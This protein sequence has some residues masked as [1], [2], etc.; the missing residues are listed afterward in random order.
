[1]KG[2][3]RATGFP[4]AWRAASRAARVHATTG[5]AS[6]G[7]FSYVVARRLG[8]ASIWP[9]FKRNERLRIELE[10]LKVIIW[11]VIRFK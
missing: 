10:F 9:V 7:F 8:T 1:M 5:P 6:A 3:S 11:L 2:G 4:E